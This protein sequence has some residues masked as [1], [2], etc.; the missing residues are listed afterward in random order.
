MAKVL[1]G[2]VP[3]SIARRISAAELC[4][5]AAAKTPRIA[6]SDKAKKNG[7]LESLVGPEGLEPPTKA[8]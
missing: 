7:Y 4:A 5:L 3:D 1:R 6:G 2:P 8:L